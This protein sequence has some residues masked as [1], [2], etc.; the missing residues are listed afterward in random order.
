MCEY[1]GCQA[2]PA[3]AE[4]TREHDE[5]VALISRTRTAHGANDVAAMANLARRIAEVLGPHTTVEEQG[6]FPALHD[7]FPDHLAALA[8][9]HRQIEH[10]LGE[11]ADGTPADPAWPARLMATLHLLREHIL[12]EQDGVF[13][14]ALSR[15]DP[16]QWEAVD[17]VRRN[18]EA[19][20]STQYRA[21]P[22]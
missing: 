6:L 1:C 7:E 21:C 8:D 11:A 20:F 4:L 16:A 5:A 9:Q 15:L 22:G 3:I 14:A 10:V 18:I 13:P 17:A 19:G 2:V 12:A